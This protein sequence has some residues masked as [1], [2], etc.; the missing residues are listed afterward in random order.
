MSNT[1]DSEKR[2]KE[3]GGIN[4]GQ[5]FKNGQITSTFSIPASVSIQYLSDEEKAKREFKN[6]WA[7]YKSIYKRENSSN[8]ER[9]ESLS[10]SELIN[11][12]KN[13]GTTSLS[14]ISFIFLSHPLYNKRATHIESLFHIFVIKFKI[15]QVMPAPIKILQR[16]L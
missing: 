16:Q 10:P 11:I 9:Y 12:E 6:Y 15:R 13:K 3:I 1:I 14:N 5:A 2:L 8:S 7:A 4:F